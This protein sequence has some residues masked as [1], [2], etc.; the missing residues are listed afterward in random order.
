MAT[1][2]LTATAE[3][4]RATTPPRRGLVDRILAFVDRLPGP[5]AA[6]WVGIGL[7][8]AAVAHVIVWMSPG[9]QIGVI[10]HDMLVP[11][12][13]F[14]W[15]AWLMTTLNRVGVWAFSEFRPAWAIQPPKTTIA[16]S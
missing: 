14:A 6:A 12:L 10:H 13:I 11:A 8:L 9:R 3:E 5:A 4:S 15:F 1:D 16:M 2:A 7:L